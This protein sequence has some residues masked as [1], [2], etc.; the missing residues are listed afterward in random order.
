MGFCKQVG[1]ENGTKIDPK[2]HRKN[3]WKFMRFIIDLGGL[4]G[5]QLEGQIDPKC[6]PKGIQ[7]TIEK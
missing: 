4:L 1:K 7:K 5:A 6:I 2:R 3:D